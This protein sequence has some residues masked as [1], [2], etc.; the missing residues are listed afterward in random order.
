MVSSMADVRAEFLKGR[1]AA[2]RKIA[3]AAPLPMSALG[4]MASGAVPGMGGAGGAGFSTYGWNYWYVL[5]LPVAVALMAASV[6]NLDKRHGLR[7]VLGLPVAPERIWWAKV[8]Y[9]LTLTFAANLVVCLAGAVAGCMGGAAPS[10]VAGVLCTVLLT[11]A[12]AWM[13]PAGLFLT[14]RFGTL[15]GIAVPL[16][17]QVAVGLVFGSSRLWWAVPMGVGIRVATPVIGVAPSGVPLPPG[18]A[19]AAL[20]PFWFAGISVAVLFAAALSAA[21]A[22]WFSRQEVA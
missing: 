17:V 16:L 13:V 14:H 18:D 9:V 4:F 2:A 3:L 6:A 8:A 1:R 5:M 21:G 7:G 22:A 20:D 19:M 15:A 12:I 10:I 11:L